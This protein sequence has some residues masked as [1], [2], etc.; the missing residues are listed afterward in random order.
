MTKFALAAIL[1]LSTGL[2]GKAI[3]LKKDIRRARVI[4]VSAL[5]TVNGYSKFYAI[6]DE[7]LNVYFAEKLDS[8]VSS[9]YVQNTFLLDST[10]ILEGDTLA[11]SIPDSV[12][13]D[14][15]QLSS[16]P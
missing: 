1:L 10:E 11:S 16:Q 15:L 9:W 8:M 4:N 7:D 6:P 14:R 3:D 5:D 2:I 12:F 13:V